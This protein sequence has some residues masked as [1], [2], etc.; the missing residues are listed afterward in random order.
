VN[1]TT[2]GLLYSPLDRVMSAMAASFGLERQALAP[3]APSGRSY[4][5]TNL[6]QQVIFPEAELAGVNHAP[7]RRRRMIQWGAV[8]ARRRASATR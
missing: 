3:N 1:N 5:I 4:F 2:I 6:L 7:E 8:A